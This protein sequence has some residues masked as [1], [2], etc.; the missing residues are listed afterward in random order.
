MK[1]VIIVSLIVMSILSLMGKETGK[2]KKKKSKPDSAIT[3]IELS[4]FFS[5]MN[6]I[7]GQKD[8]VKINNSLNKIIRE[9]RRIAKFEPENREARFTL[10]F[11]YTYLQS[12]N[13]SLYI[14]KSNEPLALNTSFKPEVVE[15]EINFL[16]GV[17]YCGFKSKEYAKSY[18]AKAIEKDKT[19]LE[20][21]K[22]IGVMKS[23]IE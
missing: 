18:Y 6:E 17:Y 10:W 23:C 14:D 8:F 5:K 2:D 15:P 21:E 11:I 4:E 13:S 22:E 16:T 7:L 3:R 9:N 12:K 20:R 1:R 19:L